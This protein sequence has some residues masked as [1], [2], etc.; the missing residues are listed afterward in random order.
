[1]GADVEA[2]ALALEVFHQIAMRDHHTF[3]PAGG[4]GGVLQHGEIAAVGVRAGVAVTGAGGGAEHQARHG[5]ERGFGAGLFLDRGE[6]ARVGDQQ[7]RIAI[8]A[9]AGEHAGETAG[10]GRKGRDRD[11]AGAKTRQQGHDVVE[12]RLQHQHDAILRTGAFGKFRRKRFGGCMQFR[13]GHGQI[14]RRDI[15]HEAVGDV[16]GLVAGAV[17]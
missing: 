8:G 13:I 14:G 9:E 4:A 5:G 16:V 2:L 6:A 17:L 3:G 15:P 7:C 1:V 10:T 12:S 11:D